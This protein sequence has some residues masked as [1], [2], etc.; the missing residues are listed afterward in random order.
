MSKIINSN[1]CLSTED[2]L[3]LGVIALYAPR[4]RACEI[5]NTVVD[6]YLKIVKDLDFKM[7][8]TLYSVITILV[9]AF[10][11]DENEYRR[12]MD[13]IEENTSNKTRQRFPSEE[14]IIE[15]LKYAQ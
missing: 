2:A 9:D 4:N 5:M 6:F 10:F 7:E 13:M 11:D 12:L 8:F 14:A 3:N 1:E 15:S